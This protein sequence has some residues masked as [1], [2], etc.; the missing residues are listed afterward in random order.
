MENAHF[1]TVPPAVTTGEERVF[2][3]HDGES[4]LLGAVNKIDDNP[5]YQ[6]AMRGFNNRKHRAMPLCVITSSY[7]RHRWFVM[8]SSLW[9]RGV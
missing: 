3:N 8:L 2:V 9:K 6:V 4:S 1:M 7:R 5:V